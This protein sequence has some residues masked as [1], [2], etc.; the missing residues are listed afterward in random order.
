MD[1]EILDK[2]KRGV[3]YPGHLLGRREDLARLVEDDYLERMDAS[4]LCGP[5]SEPTYCLSAKGCRFKLEKGR[6]AAPRDAER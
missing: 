6:R 1:R 2:M 3:F 4:F 5:D